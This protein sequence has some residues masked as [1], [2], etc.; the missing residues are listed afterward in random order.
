MG[1]ERRRNIRPAALN[2]LD[3]LVVDDRGGQGEYSMGR[4][5][6]ISIGGI[7]M[8]THIP[9][10]VG[11]QVMITLGLENELVDIMGKIKYSTF[12]AGRHHNGIEF[13]NVAEHDLEILHHYVRIFHQKY[14]FPADA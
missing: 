7:L 13:F 2:L 12:E 14:T 1:K 4:T 3:Y 10:P 6:N 9:L 5:L 11:Q 8:E